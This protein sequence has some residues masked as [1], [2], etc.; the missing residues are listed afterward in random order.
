MKEWRDA[1]SDCRKEKGLTQ[2][3]FAEKY[4]IAK[5]TLESWE[6]GV[7]VPPEYIQKALLFYWKQHE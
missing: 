6:A 1:V 3:A 2:A 5:R 7:R 4:E